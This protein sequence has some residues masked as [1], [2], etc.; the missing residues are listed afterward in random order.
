[1]TRLRHLFVPALL[2]AVACGG[3]GSAAEGGGPAGGGLERIRPAPAFA[4][5]TLDGDTLRLSDLEADA[6]A[7]LLNFWASWCVPCK[8]EIP[9]L[10]DLHEAYEEKGLAVLGVAVNDLPRDSRAFVEETGMTYPSVIGTP[11]MLEDYRLSPWLPTT[12]LVADGAVVREWVGPRTRADFE[13]PVKVALGLA[14]PL[15]DVIHEREAPA[16]GASPE[17]P[18]AD[19]GR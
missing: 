6:D 3:D 8:T 18:P 16:G 4:L 17:E 7:V 13:Y 5:E 19:P 11:A 14:P 12:L 15:E 10:V 9:E 2:V 1:M